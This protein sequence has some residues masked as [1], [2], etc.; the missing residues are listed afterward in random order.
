MDRPTAGFFLRISLKKGIL[1]LRC[2]RCPLCRWSV[3]L[4]RCR[5]T[6]I[7]LHCRIL[8]SVFAGTRSG[9]GKFCFVFNTTSP[10]CPR[11][12]RPYFARDMIGK[13]TRTSPFLLD[14]QG[15]S[16]FVLII[17]YGHTAAT[18]MHQL[19]GDFYTVGEILGH[20][21]KGIGMSLGISTNL[22]AVTAQ[23]VDVRLERKKA[24]PETY[25]KALHP[26]KDAP[27][28]DATS[29]DTPKKAKK[30][31]SGMEL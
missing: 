9:F 5:G 10:F 14:F 7:P 3:H 6:A 12:L 21:L 20:T 22:E 1:V 28:K 30:R 17:T 29:K 8:F 18:N 11:P 31:S 24:V 26:Q 4:R 15:V 25:H 27:E 16:G 19:T 2:G 23:Y 13:R